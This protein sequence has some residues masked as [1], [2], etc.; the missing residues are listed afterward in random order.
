MTIQLRIET[1][2]A[3]R[4]LQVRVAWTDSAFVASLSLPLVRVAVRI[5]SVDGNLARSPR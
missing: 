4:L 2:F 5:T 1:H 3:W